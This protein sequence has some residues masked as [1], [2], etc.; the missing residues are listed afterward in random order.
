[1]KLTEKSK[2][3]IL[4]F[5]EMGNRWGFN[6]TVAQ[7][8]ALLVISPEALSAETIAASLHIS[9]G[10]VS[11]GVKELQSWRLL[12]LERQPGDRKDYYTGAGSVWD[13]AKIVFE[14]RRQREIDPTLSLLRTMVLDPSSE[15]EDRFAERQAQELLALLE[16]MT[17]WGEQLNRLS[18]AQLTR[19]MQLGAGITKVLDFKSKAGKPTARH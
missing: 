17:A 18:P 9:R 14:Q 1:M 8:L 15:A 4:H 12:K 13:L 11:M 19:L 2:T 10:N 6:R 3:F 5:G 16:Q 7:I